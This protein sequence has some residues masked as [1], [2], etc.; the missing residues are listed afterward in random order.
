MGL[1]RFKRSL[2][3]GNRPGRLARILNRSWA[4]AHARGIAR[5]VPE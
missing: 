3:Q 4:I 2:Y 1:H 5:V